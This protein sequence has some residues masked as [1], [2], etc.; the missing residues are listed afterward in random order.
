MLRSQLPQPPEPQG[1]SVEDVIAA[2]MSGS[3]PGATLGGVKPK[4]AP[5]GQIAAT[6]GVPVPQPRARVTRQPVPAPVVRAQPGDESGDMD[7]TITGSVD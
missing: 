2:A 1:M 4:S 5:A 3:K 7:E 6:G